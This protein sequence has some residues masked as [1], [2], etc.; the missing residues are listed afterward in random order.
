MGEERHSGREP[1]PDAVCV[2]IDLYNQTLTGGV[3]MTVTSKRADPHHLPCVICYG[4]S[5]YESNS[6]KSSNPHSEIYI[7][8]TART[9]DEN[10]GNPACN[11]GGVLVLERRTDTR[12]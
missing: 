4:S 11:Q 5:A 10:G 12:P 1:R 3:S 2:G 9:L 8:D 6:M 7:A